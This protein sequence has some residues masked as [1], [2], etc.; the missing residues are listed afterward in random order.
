MQFQPLGTA[1]NFPTTA[2][3]DGGWDDGAVGY[4]SAFPYLMAGVDAATATMSL[5]ECTSAD[6]AYED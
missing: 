1:Q 2:D 4:E 5:R 3:A 6:S